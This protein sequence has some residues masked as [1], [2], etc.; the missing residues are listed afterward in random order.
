MKKKT[1]GT[2]YSYNKGCRCKE[3]KKANTSYAAQYRRKQAEQPQQPAHRKYHTWQ[4][5]E[6]ILVSDY[7]KSARQIASM[8]E[9]THSAVINRRRTLLA[10]RK[11]SE[12]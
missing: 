2:R 9:R 8:L 11:A 3:C 4:P 5:W 12:K 6:D 1:H 7:T 10:R